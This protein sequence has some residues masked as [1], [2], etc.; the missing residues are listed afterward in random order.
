MTG[1]LRKTLTLDPEVVEALRGDEAG[2]SAAVNAILRTEVERR[3][4][5]AALAGLLERLEAERGPVDQ[6]EVE[7]F[8]RLLR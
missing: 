7:E 2:L 4:R 8:R 5:A 3:R 6:G 1:K